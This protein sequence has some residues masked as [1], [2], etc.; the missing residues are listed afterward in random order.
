MDQDY[1]ELLRDLSAAEARFLVVGA[2]AMAIHA[3]P[4]TTGDIDL[5]V[6]ATS[7]NAARVYR[8]LRAFGAPLSDL[9]EAD[10]TQPGIVYQIG[11]VPHRIDIL[12]SLTGLTFA[13]AWESR[14]PGKLG[15][16]A[17]DFIGREAL[18]RNKRA[19]GRPRD[20]ADIAELEDS[21]G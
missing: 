1:L 5:W 3:R 21:S 18:I 19:V 10:L 8:A 13:E 2:F 20:L 11:I 16:H 9:R 6:E 12:T 15:D 7:E 4:R 14:V 17:C